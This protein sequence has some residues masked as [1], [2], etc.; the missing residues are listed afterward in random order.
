[1]SAKSLD[2]QYQKIEDLVSVIHRS[3]KV[4]YV[5]PINFVES[6]GEPRH[7]WF[8]YKEG[9]SSK[10]VTN[11]LEEFVC[12]KGGIVMDP[13]SGVGST[14]ITSAQL[15][16][17]SLGLDVS[18]L[19]DF[20]A[21]T[22]SINL[23]KS[24]VKS[25]DDLIRRIQESDL[26]LKSP[27]PDNPTV[28]SYFDRKDLD[29]LLGAKFLINEVE[30]Q[31][32]RDLGMLAILSL[33]EDVSTHRRAGNGV[34]RKQPSKLEAHGQDSNNRFKSSLI[35]KLEMF[36]E[37]LLASH[38]FNTPRFICNSVLNDEV[39]DA[40]GCALTSPPYANCFD[41][42]K[43]Y[44]RELWIG[45]FFT[46]K[47][48]HQRFRA[49]SIRSHVHSSW[50]ARH[51]DCGSSTVADIVV[52]L[53][54]DQELWSNKIPAMLAGY[55]MDIDAVLKRMH[56]KMITNS[57][58]GIVVGNSV[59]GGI[60]IATDLLVAEMAMQI[61]F[62]VER[63]DVYRRIIPSSQQYKSEANLRWSRESNVILRK[64]VR[65]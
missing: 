17:D 11:F 33:V 14:C 59:Y 9:F 46:S 62:R 15:G 30:C 16:F 1:M 34:K 24:E 61:G 38:L 54:R 36:K 18:P 28:I 27:D 41:Y 37:D 51:L 4:S 56:H 45:D 64:V 10:F 31:K 5:T 49:N 53:L 39:T 44:L 47:E 29:A 21:R 60:P 2:L 65:S 13:F 48:D 3:S 57:V 25:L 52:P 32:I 12:I 23:E 40:I 55:F 6:M 22:K 20:I 19:A 26:L 8:P 43:I 58:F 7:R 50:D 42:S 63:V 35:K